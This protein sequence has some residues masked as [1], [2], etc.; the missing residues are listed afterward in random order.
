MHITKW[1]WIMNIRGKFQIISITVSPAWTAT[2]GEVM[3]M[4]ENEVY[5]YHPAGFI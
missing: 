3:R 4:I 5:V 2:P 1:I